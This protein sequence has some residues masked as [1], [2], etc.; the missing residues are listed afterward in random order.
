[1]QLAN[2]LLQMLNVS[3]GSDATI[4]PGDQ[5]RL[6]EGTSLVYAADGYPFD[7]TW[8]VVRMC[9]KCL[10]YQIPPPKA[11]G[12]LQNSICCAIYCLIYSLR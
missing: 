8:L 11:P 5:L 12:R 7:G 9:F 1:M 2:A 6:K 3:L 10:P 4:M